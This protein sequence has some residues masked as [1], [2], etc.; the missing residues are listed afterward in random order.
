MR[1]YRKGFAVICILLIALS[2]RVYA[3]DYKIYKIPDSGMKITPKTDHYITYGKI[4][5]PDGM[6]APSGGIKVK[7]VIDAFDSKNLTIPEGTNSVE[8]RLEADSTGSG[9][10]YYILEENYGY[11][12]QGGYG[13]SDYSQIDEYNTMM[14]QF[15]DKFNK[16]CNLTLVPSDST[17]YGTIY[18]PDN[19]V[20]NYGGEHITISART[21]SKCYSRDITI[22]EGKNS[23]DYFICVQ[24]GKDYTVAYKYIGTSIYS[25]EAEGYYHNNLTTTLS[26][27]TGAITGT[28]LGII[29]KNENYGKLQKRS[30]T[31]NEYWEL[32][33]KTSG[34]AISIKPYIDGDKI[35]FSVNSEVI[36]KWEKWGQQMASI[37]SGAISLNFFKLKGYCLYS[38]EKSIK[39]SSLILYSSNPNASFQIKSL[40]A[41]TRYYYCQAIFEHGLRSSVSNAAKII[42]N[43]D[44]SKIKIAG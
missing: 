22:P 23:L 38:Y 9:L 24:S 36:D 11:V 18:L 13:G 33:E 30:L 40:T 35:K 28:N 15:K 1:F 39:D 12:L 44:I 16:E 3:S 34:S 5:L 37:T 17:I 2:L 19:M 4:C 21:S 10:P 29:Y 27:T 42:Y 8:Y 43:K 6:I 31:K 14:S 26:A 7:V 25:Y 32:T 41:G 20:A